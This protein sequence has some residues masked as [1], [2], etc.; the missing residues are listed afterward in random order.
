MIL[1]FEAYKTTDIHVEPKKLCLFMHECQTN[2]EKNIYNPNLGCVYIYAVV[3]I[4][5]VDLLQEVLMLIVTKTFHCLENESHSMK[6][7]KWQPKISF[8]I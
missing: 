3:L 4:Y 8:E 5:H 1:P 6:G 7:S 2:Q